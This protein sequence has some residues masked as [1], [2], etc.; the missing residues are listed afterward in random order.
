M[1]VDYD[2]TSNIPEKDLKLYRK[3]V[4][5]KIDIYQ[6]NDGCVF[7]NKEKTN[8]D[9]YESYE[10]RQIQNE[11]SKILSSSSN[12]LVYLL[13]K[14]LNSLESVKYSLI[15]CY[16]QSEVEGKENNPKYVESEYLKF[17]RQ[18]MVKKLKHDSEYAHLCRL[19][20]HPQF[21]EWMDGNKS[22]VNY[23]INHKYFLYHPKCEE[24]RERYEKPS[25][26]NS[27]NE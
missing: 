7:R 19:I 21:Y 14:N 22:F 26:S 10:H 15:K 3:Y 8:V 27:D 24:I 2:Y 25:G 12:L 23:I 4:N 18:I 9:F 17:K 20:E 5:S 1:E 6:D 11:A 13:G 16:S